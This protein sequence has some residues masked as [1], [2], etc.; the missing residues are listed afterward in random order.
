MVPLSTGICGKHVHV[1]KNKKFG[2][3]NILLVNAEV[4][5]GASKAFYYSRRPRGTMHGR[6]VASPEVLE[7]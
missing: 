5:G 3:W 1:F 4:H 6:Q 7:A 2:L